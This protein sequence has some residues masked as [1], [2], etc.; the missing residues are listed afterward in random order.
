MKESIPE[1]LSRLPDKPGVYLMKDNTSD[2]IY[3]GKAVNLK[4]RVRSYFQSG[5]HEAKVEA[6]VEHI[7]DFEYIVVENEVEALVL[8][9]NLIKTH[10]PYYNIKIKD[11]KQYPYIKLTTNEPYPRIQVVRHMEH[12]G[13]RYWGPYP[14]ASKMRETIKV[15]HRWFPL[16]TCP[17]P[18]E[19][20]EPSGK[21]CLNLHIDRCV[22]PCLGTVK[23]ET[24]KRIVKT[25]E[26][27]LDGNYHDLTNQLEKDMND[28]AEAMEFERAAELRDQITAIKAVQEKQRIIS[29]TMH[30]RDV[31]GIARGTDEAC[32]SV[33]Y[34]RDGLV[35]GRDNFFLSGTEGMSREDVLQSFLAHH[36]SDQS[37]LPPEIIVGHHLPDESA[38]EE[39][40][41]RVRGRSVHVIVPQRG[42]KHNLLALADENA[43]VAMS[44]RYHTLKSQ[45]ELRE[46]SLTEL[47]HYLGLTRL[48]DR[49]ECYDIS[50]TQGTNSVA[51]MVVFLHGEP[52]NSHYRHFKIKTVEGPNDFAS[53]NEVLKRRF[54]HEGK[55]ESFS[56]R[57]DL[58]IVDGGK[59][60]L[61][62]AVDAMHGCGV[63]DIPVCGLA[64][65]NEWLFLPGRPEPVMLPEGSL[66]LHLVQRIRDEAHRF[67]ITYHRKLR[68]QAQTRSI[69]EGCP[70]I[71]PNRR[72]ALLRQFS[73]VAAMKK[74]DVEELAA[75]PGMNR[76]AAE[77][78]YQ[79][80][81][82][83]PGQEKP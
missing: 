64:K 72:T 2:I 5:P 35:T 78:L 59:G 23:P 75:V 71:G 58:V 79:Y 6:M 60:Q 1:K 82:A 73:S 44:E 13:A 46:Q 17:R 7:A 54:T 43:R 68:Q 40:L 53:M 69:L 10:R 55:D 33:F 30:D 57:P 8:E 56:S 27:F 26:M 36:Y 51:S 76:T 66:P 24:Y 65:Q 39:M 16:R 4:N 28:A 80:L 50:N 67:A 47:Q 62:Y 31:V 81:R 37:A 15:L 42:E 19:Y 11:D 83:L 52:M 61:H 70:G 45:D 38:V 63:S 22:G 74:A 34:V 20:G 29:A 14:S 9:Q 21:P 49:I 48:P 18:L 77:T 12:D 25:V 32:I 41:S 3:V